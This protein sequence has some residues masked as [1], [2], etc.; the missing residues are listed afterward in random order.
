[1]VALY[2][3]SFGAS[4]SAARGSN[5]GSP[6]INSNQIFKQ[7]VTLI[8]KG[9]RTTRNSKGCYSY[10]IW[11]PV[12]H[13]DL[14]IP[15]TGW[16]APGWSTTATPPPA[17]PARSSWQLATRRWQLRKPRQLPGGRGR[18]ERQLLLRRSVRMPRCWNL[19]QKNKGVFLRHHKAILL[20]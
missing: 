18:S 10:Q 12:W 8:V 14:Q 13:P 3:G 4:H 11:Q 9:R 17:D 16:P 19:L 15:E 20:F 1:M 5:P 6:L 2:R 7:T